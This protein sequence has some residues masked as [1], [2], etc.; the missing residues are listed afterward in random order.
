MKYSPMLLLLFILTLPVTSAAQEDNGKQ[1]P[2]DGQ[3]TEKT[4]D[5]KES[6]DIRKDQPAPDVSESFKPSEEISEDLSVSFPVDI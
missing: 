5:T 2:A 6:P 3:Q 1:R 4:K